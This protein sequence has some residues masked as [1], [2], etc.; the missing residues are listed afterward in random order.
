MNK[1]AIFTKRVITP[2]RVIPQGV[3]LIEGKKILE[4]DNRFTVQFDEREFEIYHCENSTLLPGFIDVHIH[5]CAGRDVM[6]GTQE[7]IEAISRFLAGHGTTGYLATTVTA[8]PFATLQAVESL[9]KLIPRGNR[10]CED[11][12]TSPGRPIHQRKE[13]RRPPG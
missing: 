4:V 11:L 8:S 12:G 10:W 6:E 2:E 7:A 1:V 5:G 13:K 9:G 3:V